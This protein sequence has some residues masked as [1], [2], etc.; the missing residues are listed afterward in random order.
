MKRLGKIVLVLLFMIHTHV[1][2][3]EN[4]TLTKLYHHANNDANSRN[5]EIG[6]LVFYFDREPVVTMGNTKQKDTFVFDLPNVSIESPEVKQMIASVNQSKVP[7]YS[8]SIARVKSPVNGLRIVMK[9][10]PDQIGVSLEQFPTIRMERGLIVHLHNKKMLHQIT[11]TIERPVLTVAHVVIDCGH[12]GADS[13]AIGCGG[14]KEKDIT[15][16]LGLQVADLL[17]EKGVHT[18]LTRTKDETL[19]LAQRTLLANSSKADAFISIHA[20]S[21]SRESVFGIETFC[22]NPQQ[23]VSQLGTLTLQEKNKATAFFLS[24]CAQ[25]HQLAQSVH[26]KV[27]AQ[28]AASQFIYTDRKVKRA[29]TQLLLGSQ[30]PAVL[31][32][33]GFITNEAEAARLQESNYQHAVAQGISNGILTFLQSKNA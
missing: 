18:T 17:Q 4:S 5:V 7:H 33:V 1:V 28:I 19:S 15:L 27:L 11:E 29:A 22:L 23:F 14:V 6:S 12:G 2:G 21:A 10:N 30:M 31:I 26:S 25:S 9:F 24:K 8:I 13:G 20:N 32:E 16:V 3:K